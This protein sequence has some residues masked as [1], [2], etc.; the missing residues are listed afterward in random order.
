MK[1]TFEEM[2]QPYLLRIVEDN[3]EAIT[4][5]L[6]QVWKTKKQHIKLDGF[7]PGA[8]PQNIAE[9]KYGFQNLYD[10]YINE[11]VVE[12]I[13]QAEK[14]NDVT[15][16]DVQQIYPEK[17]DK[18]AI[19]MQ[20][21]T[22]VRPT[23]TVDYSNLKVDQK[24]LTVSEDLI[25]MQLEQVREG[26]ALLVPILDRGV[27]LGDTL[28]ISFEGS[29]N[30]VPFKGGTASRQ[31]YVLQENTFIPDFV[32]GL[33]GMQVEETRTVSVTFPENY[34]VETL[35]G[36]ETSFELTV[37]EISRRDLPSLDDDFAKTAGFDSLQEMKDATRQE[38]A[39]RQRE[40]HQAET[41]TALVTQLLG[42]AEISPMPQVMVKRYLD[43]MLQQ[44]LSQTGLSEKDFFEKSNGSKEQFE[45]TYYNIAR[46]DLKVQ[47]I[48]DYIARNEGFVISNEEHETYVKDEATRLGMSPGDLKDLVPKPQIESRI[49]MRKAY[50]YLLNNAE[51]V[52][53]QEEQLSDGTEVESIVID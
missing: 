6:A 29:I 1:T 37:H 47:L 25:D 50:D 46:R 36:K 12:A 2:A 38:L 23:V 5:G 17:L 35:A 20:A 16:V 34:G 3:K 15:I 4:E 28:T 18:E 30:G 40:L 8:V 32:T 24:E 51:Y 53:P 19:V 21:V 31:T 44:Q 13:K 43:Q 26:Q 39:N 49:L 11:V 10:S 41:E 45:S 27:E 7:R 9:A 33:L 42:K 52:V 22:Y 14:D 48:L